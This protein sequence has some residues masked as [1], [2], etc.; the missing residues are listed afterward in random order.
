M[1]E[2]HRFLESRGNHDSLTSTSQTY[3][4]SVVQFQDKIEEF[5]DQALYLHTRNLTEYPFKH[6][7]H[8]KYKRVVNG[9]NNFNLCLLTSKETYEFSKAF[10]LILHPTRGIPP[11]LPET[12]HA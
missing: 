2:F 3:F 12:F 1:P 10:G 7:C 11:A 8:E 6:T 5:L 9:S 4:R